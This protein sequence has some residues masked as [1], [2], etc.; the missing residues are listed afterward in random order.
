MR[1]GALRAQMSLADLRA[2]L[3]RYR[4]SV[5]DGWTGVP[6]LNGAVLRRTEGPHEVQWTAWGREADITEQFARAGAMVRDVAP[7]SLH[8]ATLALL[9]PKADRV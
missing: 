6:S 9:N 1:G 3:R 7:L 4:A 5:P 8:D 2:G